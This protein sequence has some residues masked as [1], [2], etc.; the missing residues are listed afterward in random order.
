MSTSFSSEPQ[1]I[2]DFETMNREVVS[3]QS[4]DDYS[5]NAPLLSCSLATTDNFPCDAEECG[6]V[7]AKYCVKC[8]RSYCSTHLK[9]RSAIVSYD[10]LK[11]VEL[12]FDIL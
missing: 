5:D 8:A 10:K 2:T 4:K 1:A 7:A 12:I 9:V 3:S 11:G 6:S